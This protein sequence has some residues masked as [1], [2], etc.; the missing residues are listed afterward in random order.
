MRVLNNLSKSDFETSFSL[1][2]FFSFEGSRPR[3]AGWFVEEKRVLMPFSCPMS[4]R[5]IAVS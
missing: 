2:N 4:I 5:A 1:Q 3:F